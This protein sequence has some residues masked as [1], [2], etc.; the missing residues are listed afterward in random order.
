MVNKE[1][2]KI[3]V[4][5]EKIQLK[6]SVYENM[7]TNADQAMKKMKDK[8]NHKRNKK[9]YDY[10]IDNHVSVKIPNIDHGGTEL[11]RLRCVIVYVHHDK[12]QLACQWGILEDLYGAHHL[13][14]Y[15]GLIEF[16]KTIENPISL[17]SAAIAASNGK[18]DKPMNEVES[19][20]MANQSQAKNCK[21]F[22][23]GLKCNSHC[24][25]KTP[26]NKFKNKD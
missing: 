7:R 6:E 9:T 20:C 8:H 4:I 5:Q 13:A 1:N 26:T 11:R 23:G 2:E 25:S 24:H 19:N 14:I 3:K 18:R 15:H 10:Q 12:Y 21:C 22:N 17:R 16:D